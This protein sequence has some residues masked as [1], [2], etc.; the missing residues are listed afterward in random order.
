MLPSAMSRKRVAG[1]VLFALG[2]GF[3]P[4]ATDLLPERLS[5]VSRQVE[6]VRGRKFERPVPATEIDAAEARRVLRAKIVEGIPTTA[7]EYLRSLAVLGLIEDAPS[8]F[9]RL[10]DFYASQVVAF[11]DPAPHRFFVVQ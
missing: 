2:A 11:Y 7:D 5:E 9:D 1:A 10:V 4:A 8:A 6:E 3:L